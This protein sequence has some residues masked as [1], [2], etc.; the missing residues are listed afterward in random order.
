MSLI[1]I[2]DDEPSMREF[3]RILLEKDG[4][5]VHT[6]A[7]GTAAIDLV[8]S[9]DFDLIISDIR[10]PGMNGLELLAETKKRRPELPVIM[11]TAY[12]SP[13]DAVKAMKEGAFD[14]IT[15]PFKVEEIKRVIKSATARKAVEQNG[16]PASSFAEIIG[17]SPEMT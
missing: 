11:I 10:M 3:L 2:V 7:T 15:K 14:Y 6:A 13:D 16:V 12:A 9:H 4:H 1:L 17:A 8:T 5:A